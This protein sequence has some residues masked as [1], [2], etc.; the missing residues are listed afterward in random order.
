[1]HQKKFGNF[2]SHLQLK[3]LFSQSQWKSTFFEFSFIIGGDTE[4]ALTFIMPVSIHNARQTDIA[5][6]FSQYK[7]VFDN[8]NFCKGGYNFCF[9][10]YV[11][12]TL[13]IFY[14]LLRK[15]MLMYRFGHRYL[16]R[17]CTCWKMRMM[18]KFLR[19]IIYHR[20]TY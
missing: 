14:L 19:H 15:Q 8:L 1:V 12:Q 16:K 10:V 6:Q 3:V 20:H 5:Q 9:F 18:A 7:I 4:K 2:L 13:N 11:F 17:I